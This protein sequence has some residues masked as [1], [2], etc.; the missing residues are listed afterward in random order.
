[1]I[2]KAS[3]F[4]KRQTRESEFSYFDGSWEELEKLTEKLY[5]G[6]LN[7]RPGYRDGVRLVNVPNKKGFYS[8]VVPISE[9]IEITTVFEARREGEKP[10][11]KSIAYGKKVP[12]NNVAIVLYRKDVLEE[13]PTD[14]ESLTGADWEIVS[15]N[16]SPYDYDLP[17]T[18]SA[19]ARNQL[20][21]TEDG[22]GGT[23]ANY[24]G[25]EFA[26]AITFWNT[27]TLV[28]ERETCPVCKSILEYA[29]GIGPF[30]PNKECVVA[31]GPN[32]YRNDNK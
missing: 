21:D 13:D 15:V 6:A 10:F 9:D 26:K 17:M 27:H 1:M 4:V 20:A 30:C 24:T 12:A 5:M 28:R 25:D 2:I 7:D 14:R 29:P 3:N 16:C 23:K 22:K 32:L 19:M 18:P 8:A 11:K 31:D